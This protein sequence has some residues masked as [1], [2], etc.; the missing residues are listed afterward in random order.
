MWNGGRGDFS[1]NLNQKVNK[2]AASSIHAIEVK[3]EVVNKG[4]A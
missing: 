4:M 3:K 2:V 1:V